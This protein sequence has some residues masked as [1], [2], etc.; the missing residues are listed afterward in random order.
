MSAALALVVISAVL[1][2][3]IKAAGP[4]VLGS[5]PLP[6]P[7]QRMMTLLAPALLTALV[8]TNTFASGRHLVLDARA[9]GVAAAAVCIALRAPILLTV[10][11]AAVVTAGLRAVTA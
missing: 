7:A 10:V 2:M 3:T 8:L 5:H 6:A 11:A 9:A 4:L 1:T